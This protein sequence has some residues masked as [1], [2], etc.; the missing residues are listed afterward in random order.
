MKVTNNPLSQASLN[1]QTAK[2]SSDKL[3]EIPAIKSALVNKVDN[4]LDINNKI[5]SSSDVDMEKVNRVRELIT[6]GN[7]TLD[8]DALSDAILEMHRR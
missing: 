6:Q 4:F 5:A 2:V 3:N 1:N 8:L 7:L